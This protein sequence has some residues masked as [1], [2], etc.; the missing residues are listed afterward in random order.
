MTLVLPTVIAVR[1]RRLDFSWFRRPARTVS[2]LLCLISVPAALRLTHRSFFP[3]PPLVPV[4]RL[5]SALFFSSVPSRSAFYTPVAP[6]F[7]SK[8]I[9]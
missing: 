4:D 5:L 2:A 6:S 1:G 8:P 3:E 7:V 9:F